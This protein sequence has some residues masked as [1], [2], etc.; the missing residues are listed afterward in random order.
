M[1]QTH[2]IPCWTLM[3]VVLFI[4]LGDW[5]QGY[6][7]SPKFELKVLVDG[8]LQEHL[9][10]HQEHGATTINLP[11]SSIALQAELLSEDDTDMI[12][13]WKRRGSGT[14]QTPNAAHTIYLPPDHKIDGLIQ[15]I[16]TLTV[17]N[18][19]D[20][21]VR[22]RIMVTFVYN[23]ALEI[24]TA[25]PDP[26]IVPLLKEGDAYFK[27]GEY[28]FAE[29]VYREVIQVR[30]TT[31]QACQR[32][33]D[34]ARIYQMIG[35]RA[36][37]RESEELEILYK[38][39]SITIVKFMMAHLLE[40]ITQV[41]HQQEEYREL[42]CLEIQKMLDAYTC[43]KMIYQDFIPEHLRKPGTIQTW[44]KDIRNYIKAWKFYSCH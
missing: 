4:S 38:T 3:F 21:Y 6:A 24:P 29:N 31:L 40:Y 15:A 22:K 2:K 27:N 1:I 36:K 37:Q 8:T 18:Q 12:F 32:L 19:D 39:Q 17:T 23:P 25:Q 42:E 5:Q 41:Q 28:K 34:I 33:T 20:E 16:I 35:E 14:L 7:A 26:E 9:A 30:P 11:A 13:E 44:N 10:A 43:L